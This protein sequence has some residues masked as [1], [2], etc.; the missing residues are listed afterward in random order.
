MTQLVYLSCYVRYST[1]D[2]T[3]GTA[4]RLVPGLFIPETRINFRNRSRFV[5]DVVFELIRP[6]EFMYI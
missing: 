3:L 1:I 6:A 2:E 4:V 5:L